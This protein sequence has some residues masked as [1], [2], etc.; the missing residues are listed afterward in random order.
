MRA[1][2]ASYVRWP[3]GCGWVVAA[4]TA[5][6]PP[7]RPCWRLRLASL[8]PPPPPAYPRGTPA[9]VVTTPI[10]WRW[11][12]VDIPCFFCRTVLASHSRSRRRAGHATCMLPQQCCAL[13][14]RFFCS[15]ADGTDLWCFPHARVLSFRVSPGCAS[16]AD[17]L[18]E[19]TF[20]S[21]VPTIG[22]NAVRWP[23]VLSPGATFFSAG[24]HRARSAGLPAAW[25]WRGSVAD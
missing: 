4:S 24:A 25:I 12:V 19:G 6:G 11:D 16:S 17:R 5:G 1:R 18:K 15:F 22:F 2:Q 21:T 7:R 20:H 9:A 8:P 23:P 10:F 3:A 14:P 13:G